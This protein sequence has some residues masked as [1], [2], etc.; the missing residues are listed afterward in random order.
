VRQRRGGFLRGLGIRFGLLLGGSA[1]AL[2]AGEGILRFFVPTIAHSPRHLV[3]PAHLSVVFTPDPALMPGVHGPSRFVT[4]SIGIRGD[5]IPA[6]PSYRILAIGGSTTE[7]LFLDQTETWPHLLQQR[8]SEAS[9][10][11]RVW[12]GNAGKSGLTTRDHIVQLRYLLPELPR[13]DAIVFL[14]GVNDLSMRN[15]QDSDYDPHFM[16]RGRAEGE[17]LP[18]AFGRYPLD[19]PALPW[20]R[21]LALWE[22]AR[23][24][25]R[26]LR[27][28]ARDIQ[29]AAGRNYA[30]W[31]AERQAATRIRETVPELKAALEEYARNLNTL[32]DLARERAIRPIFLTQPTV[33]RADLPPEFEPLLWVGKIGEGGASEYYSVAVLAAEMEMYNKTLLR[34]CRAR[35]VECFDLAARVP[36][37]G[38]VFYD[39]DH[40]NE[41][42][43]ELVAHLVAG[44]MRERLPFRETDAGS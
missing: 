24:T 9:P 3:W 34:T 16:A 13:L 30:R 44:F 10:T 27:A 26:G 31:R 5:E 28:T 35:Q 38:T 1:A 18:R 8:L 19:D 6:E 7:C 43:A 32:V 21:R 29:D 4:S 11:R 37:D 33:W 17:L 36:K 14:T 15:Q 23:N 20:H 12:V 22:L 41:R 25:K 39:D 2:L 42:G 40:Y